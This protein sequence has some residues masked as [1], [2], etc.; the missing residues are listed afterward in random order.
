MRLCIDLTEIMG[1]SCANPLVR[2][3][4]EQWLECYEKWPEHCVGSHALAREAVET[5]E[6]PPPSAPNPYSIDLSGILEL[7]AD[8]CEVT[9]SM[10][11][12]DCIILTHPA[13][14]YGGKSKSVVAREARVNRS[15]ER[16]TSRASKPREVSENTKAP[17]AREYSRSEALAEAVKLRD[18]VNELLNK[19]KQDRI[20]MPE[21]KTSWEKSG[22]SVEFATVYYWISD[23]FPDKFKHIGDTGAD[24]E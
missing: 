14:C 2:V 1:L 23:F 4:A 12:W 22:N 15:K 16:Q 6:P 5:Y 18:L 21:L 9:V 17:S 11:Q 20:S 8:S 3:T 13:F 10:D 19:T 7:D 24:D